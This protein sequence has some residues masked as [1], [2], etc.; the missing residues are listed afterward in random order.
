[1]GNTAKELAKYIRKGND[2]NEDVILRAGVQIINPIYIKNIPPF[3]KNGEDED[4]LTFK[5]ELSSANAIDFGVLSKSHELLFSFDGINWSNI[6]KDNTGMMFSLEYGRKVMFKTNEETSFQTIGSDLRFWTDSSGYLTV[7][8]KVISLVNKKLV[9][10]GRG[11]I[12]ASIFS[13]FRFRNFE[14]LSVDNKF[15]KSLITLFDGCVFGSIST[16]SD[17]LDFQDFISHSNSFSSGSIIIFLKNRNSF[18]ELFNDITYNLGRDYHDIVKI[19]DTETPNILPYRNVDKF[20]FGILDRNIGAKSIFDCGYFFEY[21]S[22][23]LKPWTLDEIYNI[24]YFPEPAS[25]SFIIN[26]DK[27]IIKHFLGAEYNFMNSRIRMQYLDIFYPSEF[28][29]IMASANIRESI[30]NISIYTGILLS[31]YF[32]NSERFLNIPY[33]IVL[34]PEGNPSSYYDLRNDTVISNG[35]YEFRTLRPVVEAPYFEVNSSA[36]LYNKAQENL[37]NAAR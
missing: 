16:D 24:Q 17:A 10:T 26:H 21:A 34:L 14:L 4:A 3:S 1:M 33:G 30:N 25:Q 2:E 9:N 35:E 27:N 23:H 18:R 11:D 22:N 20:E 5:N 32:I 15:D 36:E 28:Y 7:T 29:P 13:S 8:G 12:T 37:N 31:A 19:Y 6:P